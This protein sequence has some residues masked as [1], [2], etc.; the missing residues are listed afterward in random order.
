[1]YN[2]SNELLA[3][4]KLSKPLNKDF[5]KLSNSKKYDFIIIDS[6][7]SA[8]GTIRRNP[9]IFYRK[10]APDFKK[11]ITVQNQLMNTA[12]MLVKKNGIFKNN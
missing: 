5:T 10:K 4:A 9:E 6:P 3:T 8:I 11:I 1:M 7:C 12:K 2:D